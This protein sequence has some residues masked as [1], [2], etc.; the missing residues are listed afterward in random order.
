MQA[1]GE[2]HSNRSSLQMHVGCSGW[3]HEAWKARFYPLSIETSNWLNYYS[4]IFDFA[5]I[6]SSYYVMPDKFMVKNWYRKT[7]AR[8]KFTAKFPKVITHDKR[9]TNVKDELDY[10]FT[11][12][13]ELDDKLLC[14]LIQLPPSMKISEG[15][16]LLERALPRFDPAFR[17]AVEVR[18]NSWYQDLAYDFFARNNMCM[19]WSRLHD[20][21]TP[22]VVTTD[23]VYLRLIGN[24]W[25]DTYGKV[26][27][28]GN[29]E[30]QYWT[31]KIKQISLYEEA[32]NRV[33]GVV[34]SASNSYSGFGPDT[35]N[36]F[37]KFIGLQE[38]QWGDTSGI[39]KKISEYENPLKQTRLADFPKD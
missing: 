5:E 14:L 33:S 1:E 20:L 4:K 31:N 27:D 16:E 19:V 9:L 13:R 10:F 7:P 29:T 25:M 37:R 35:A 34:V 32:A 15:L 22:P 18:D 24:K 3:S 39:Q 12:M 17:Y 36:S 21:Q 38:L 23:F 2:R 28:D 8:F 11:S 26:Q 6:D 30:L